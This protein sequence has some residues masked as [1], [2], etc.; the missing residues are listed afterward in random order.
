[1]S[2]LNI[3]YAGFGGQGILF[4]GKFLAYEG[5]IAGKHVSWLPSY[6]PEMRGGTANCSVIISDEEV[7]SPIVDKPDVLV[8]MNLPSLDKYENEVV[9]GGKIF[10][11]STLIERKVERTD[12]D[13]FYVPATGMA[14][15]K[16]IPTLANMIITGKMLKEIG[17]DLDNIDVVLGKIVSARHQDLLEVNKDAIKTGYDL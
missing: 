6:G 17:I 3:L 2:A 7:G 11:D 8:V 14:A 10:V 13:V 5:L 16:K 12:V 15:E 9:P 4:S 1:M